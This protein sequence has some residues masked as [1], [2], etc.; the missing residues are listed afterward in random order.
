MT[1]SRA[2]S[3]AAR[4]VALQQWPDDDSLP[5]VAEP[6]LKAVWRPPSSVGSAIVARGTANR[7]RVHIATVERHIR[8]GKALGLSGKPPRFLVRVDEFP[9]ADARS[10]PA[11]YGVDFSKRF[12]AALAGTR[13]LL[14]IVPCPAT[15]PREPGHSAPTSLNPDE[16]AL[17]AELRA[18]GVAFGLHGLTHRTR[19]RESWRRS[20]LDGLDPGGLNEL[21]DEGLGRLEK[22]GVVP[23]VL[24]PPFNRFTRGQWATLA[25]RFDVICGGPETIARMGPLPTPT[26]Q[27]DAVYLPAYPPL[28]GTARSMIDPV[29]RLVDAEPGVWVPIVLHTGWEADDDFAALEELAT[30]LAPV[31]SDWS[32]FLSAV[33]ATR[34]GPSTD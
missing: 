32:D 2:R 19:R 16:E 24:V 14:A 4:T 13:Y 17:I 27:G 15:A 6:N 8:A 28:Y 31:A 12:H 25:R 3:D 20:E 22:L 7:E 23:R 34:D 21:L 26:W 9:H 33:A 29:R 18:A 30:A 11:R 1:G 5:G 10:D